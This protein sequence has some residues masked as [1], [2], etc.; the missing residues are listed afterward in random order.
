M[1]PGRCAAFGFVM[2][3]AHAYALGQAL[4]VPWFY[5]VLNSAPKAAGTALGMVLVA[6]V[7]LS[8]SSRRSCSSSNPF[9]R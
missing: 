7:V 2:M 4:R 6:I 9:L 3:V 1:S 8:P 5:R